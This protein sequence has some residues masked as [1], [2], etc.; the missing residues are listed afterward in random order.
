LV[1]GS[2]VRVPGSFPDTLID[3]LD[4][5]SLQQIRRTFE[6]GKSGGEIGSVAMSNTGDA[7]FTQLFDGFGT[8][9][10][11]PLRPEIV[12]P[13]RGTSTLRTFR[14]VTGASQDG[15]V[16]YVGNNYPGAGLFRFDPV[17]GRFEPTSMQT[18]VL[19]IAQN[20]TGSLIVLNQQEVRDGNLVRLGDLPAS[21]RGIA[22]AP[23]LPLAYTMD[24]NQ[25][26]RRFDLSAP[27]AGGGFQEILPAIAITEIDTTY[28][29]M[30]MIATPD[31][32][33]VFVAG[34]DSILL[35]P[36]P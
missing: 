18:D 33:A 15:A 20:R 22:L 7:V 28:G 30:H 35:V 25:T 26:L 14:G 29:F 3:E 19:H 21:T 1:P 12:E 17:N 24:A 8:Y 5:V 31:G 2:V 34:H 36:L 27:L 32:R 16:V 6:E 4:P 13:L 9:A 11:S 23:T 10:F